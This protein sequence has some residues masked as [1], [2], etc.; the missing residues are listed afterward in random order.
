MFLN[1]IWG[2]FFNFRKSKIFM[3]RIFNELFFITFSI[4]QKF[5]LKFARII[6]IKAWRDQMVHSRINNLISDKIF[7]AIFQLYESVLKFYKTLFHF[8]STRQY[9]SG[10]WTKDP[11]GNTSQVYDAQVRYFQLNLCLMS[12]QHILFIEKKML[13]RPVEMLFLTSL[14]F[15]LLR[16]WLEDEKK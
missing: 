15:I 10:L 1:N 3:T 6:W 7:L 11:S 4:I 16:S 12:V 8:K 14:A 2:T 5:A 13:K 9:F